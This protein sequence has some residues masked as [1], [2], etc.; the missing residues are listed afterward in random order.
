MI[1]DVKNTKENV[2][3]LVST[4][5]WGSSQSRTLTLSQKAVAHTAID[6]GVDLVVGSHPHILQGIEIYNGRAIFY[7]LGNLVLDHDHP[8]FMPTVKESILLK[9]TIHEKK[10]R[11]LSFLPTYI[12]ND[13]RPVILSEEDERFKI[14]QESMEKISGKTRNHIQSRNWSVCFVDLRVLIFKSFEF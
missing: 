6:S 7:N 9:C 11:E 8:M 1:E 3:V 2:D 4:F 12:E 5:H 14:I 13:G 10:I